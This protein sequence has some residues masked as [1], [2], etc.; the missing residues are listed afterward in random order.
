M[1]TWPAADAAPWCEPEITG[2]GRLPMRTPFWSHTDADAARAGAGAALPNS[3][4]VRSLDGMWRFLGVDRPGAAPRGWETPAFVD[5]RWREVAVPG[6]FTM[7][8][9]ATPIYTNI[10]M[11]FDLQPP[12]VPEDNPT[13][14]YRTTFTVPRA[15]RGRRIVLQVGGAESVLMVWIDGTPIGLAKDSRLASEFDLTDHVRSGGRH[16]LAAMV[17]RWSDASYLEDQD[18]WWHGGIH[19]SVRLLSTPQV[20]LA[21]VEV[22]AGLADDLVTGTLE[23]TVHVGFPDGADR[24]GWRVEAVLE[25]LEGRR[26]TRS[27]LTGEVPGHTYP[28]LYEGAFVRLATEIPRVRRWSH[29]TPHRYRLLVTLLDPTGA[30]H[31]VTAQHVGFRRVEIRDRELLINGR[32][33]LIR[34]VNRHDF[35]PNTG[36]VVTV[37]QM[38]ADLVLMKRFGFNAVRT[39]HSP[40]APEFYDLCDEL[41]LYV[42]D[43]ANIESHAFITSLCHDPRYVAA[44]IDRGAR[45]VRRDRNHP[46][47]ICWSL[48]NESGYGAAHDALGA[49]IRRHDPSRPLHYEGAIMGWWDRPQTVTDL[50]CPMYPEIADIVDW[51]RTGASKGNGDLPLIMCEYSHAMGNSNGTL[52]EYWDAIE[53]NHGLQGGFIWEFWDHGLRQTLPDGT[54]R[55]A[56]GGDFGDPTDAYSFCLDGV[57]WP[58]RTPKPALE[59]HKHLAAPVRIEARGTDGARRGRLRLTNRRDFTDLGDL[60]AEWAVLADGRRVAGGRATLP[61]AAPGATVPWDL[62]VEI[63]RNASG[64]LLLSVRFRTARATDWCERGFEVA[65]LQLPIGLRPAPCVA[66]SVDL[67]VSHEGVEWSNGVV[68][69][70]GG[71]PV[72]LTDLEI[73]GVALLEAGPVLSLF[74]A[75]TDNDGIR[76]MAG[77]P[78]PAGR[79]RRWGLDALESEVISTRARM[80]AGAPVVDLVVHFHGL[81]GLVFEHRRRVTITPEGGITFAESLEVPERCDDLPRVGTALVLPGSFD[82]VE[83]Y[84]RG[85]HESYPDRARGARLGR[86]TSTVA[87]QYVPYVRPQEHGHHTDTRWVSV[88]DGHRGLLVTA[89]APFGFSALDHSVAALDAAEHD[90]DLVAEPVTHLHV[91]ARMR[92]LGTASCGPDTL[93][94][95]L[96]RGRRFRWAWSL[97]P[98]R[99]RPPV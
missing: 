33:V 41:G 22:T 55:Y 1:P 51:A 98:F 50:V 30:V 99:G 42:I 67:T 69:R 88:S 48:G 73:D 25:T 20:H 80:R 29:E 21:D 11:P 53:S 52:G 72:G 26:V 70:F 75:P 19:R 35:D 9:F 44:W 54:T 61:D 64:E 4:W 89:P 56:Y 79:W 78:T 62:P 66:R 32:P 43:E 60:R 38:R 83:W 93:P 81:D 39:S 15:W 87:E 49:W 96:V 58:D 10:A 5:A 65:H 27:P 68:S 28:Y 57:V 46:S 3:P 6:C 63:P 8:G 31:E 84:G 85:P 92:G 37:E 17:V 97:R 24:A 23:A 77:M 95:Y 34:G 18:Q 36:R 82:R 2:I 86:F 7:Q 91:D 59:E 71:G 94:Q 13:G 74:R 40:N 90:V 45:M 76:P 16:T 12:A 14:L 47:I